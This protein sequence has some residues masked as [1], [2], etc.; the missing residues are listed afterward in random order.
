MPDPQRVKVVG[1]RCPCLPKAGTVRAAPHREVAGRIKTVTVS[2]TGRE[3][4]RLDPVRRRRADAG[5]AEGG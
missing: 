1:G 4:F 3:A 5:A 2:G